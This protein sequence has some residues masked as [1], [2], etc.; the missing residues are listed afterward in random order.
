MLNT[1]PPS[2]SCGAIAPIWTDKEAP[3]DVLLPAT[4]TVYL[5][6][7]EPGEPSDYCKLLT[8]QV[9]VMRCSLDSDYDLIYRYIGDYEPTCS[10]AFCGMN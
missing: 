10:L 4:I 1:C 6:V 3:D 9:Q 8:S 7:Y 5:S 2:Y